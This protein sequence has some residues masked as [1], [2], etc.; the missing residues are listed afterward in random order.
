MFYRSE[1]VV[2]FWDSLSAHWSRATGALAAGQGWLTLERIPANAP[3]P[4]PVELLWCS[5]KMRELNN[6]ADD[7]DP[8]Q[9]GIH[10]IN[11]SS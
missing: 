7:A 3:E 6:L 10:R 11:T 4:N 8:T 1:N 5:L 2:L 9:R